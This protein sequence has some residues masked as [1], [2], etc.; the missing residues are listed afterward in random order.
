MVLLE[1]LG[2]DDAKVA[3]NA[4]SIGLTNVGT[5]ELLVLLVGKVGH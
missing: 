5:L 4:N 3:T 1:L 2:M